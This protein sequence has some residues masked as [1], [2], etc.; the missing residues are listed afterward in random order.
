MSN[1]LEKL[2]AQFA[3]RRGELLSVD[4]PEIGE[5]IYYR[6]MTLKQK[7]AIFD[8][9]PPF[10][11][12]AMRMWIHRALDQ[13]GEPLFTSANRT[14]FLH[15]IDPRVIERVAIEMYA[16]EIQTIEEAEKK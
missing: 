10:E 9:D 6:A 4:V 13:D 1:L 11:E 16:T 5:K 2:K 14:E 8:G 7:L 12:R 3:A 15:H